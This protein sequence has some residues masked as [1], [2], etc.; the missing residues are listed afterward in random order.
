MSLTASREALD[1][2][3]RGE[4]GLVLASLIASFGDFDL[5]EDALQDAVAAAL[6]RWPRDGVPRSPAAWLTVVARRR[7]VDRLRHQGMRADKAAALQANEELRHAELTAAEANESVSDERLRLLFTCCHPAL[8]SEARVALTLRTLGGLSTEAVALA[9]LLPVPTL[10]K[11]L[12][13]AKR[14]IRDARIPYRVPPE[15]EWT[16]RLDSVLAVLYLVFNEGYS[17]T[18][19]QLEARRALCEEAIRLARVLATLLPG[20]SEVH[21]LLALMLLH[22]ARRTAR[23]G[24]DGV[25]VP[26]DEQDRKRWHGDELREGLA[27][28]CTAAG[29]RGRGPYQ[30]QAAIAA[31]HAVTLN[32]ADT[33]WHLVAALYAELEA[34]TP[35]PVVRVNRAV[36]EGRARE[37]AA[38]LALLAAAE[39]WD[40]ARPL[41]AYQPYHAARADLLQRAGRTEE[42]VAA[43][44]TALELCRGEP[45]R[46]FLAR[47]LA[48]ISTTR[49]GDPGASLPRGSRD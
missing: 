35:S 41:K 30:V 13:R 45:E 20:E 11:R 19:T 17:A 28:L 23:F 49:S 37:P 1:E 25:L 24:P 16:A 47:R 32:G 22:D 26:L 29:C 43:Y 34:L 7:V 9:F 48:G 5:A 10:A 15:T 31:A 36:A 8:S 14:K 3:V 2:I 40:S 18:D 42:A 44:R 6:E 27:A 38:G 33:P 39:D 21:A 12:E 4:S 46:R